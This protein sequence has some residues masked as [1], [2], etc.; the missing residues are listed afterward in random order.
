MKRYRVVFEL[1]TYVCEIKATNEDEAWDMAKESAMNE[2]GY[3]IMK[4][5]E[6]NVEEI[7]E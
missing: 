2:I 7:T 3:D 6:G 1:G 4:H 5:A